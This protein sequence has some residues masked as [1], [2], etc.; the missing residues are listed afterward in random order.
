MGFFDIFS[1][2]GP[3][4]TQ[5]NSADAFS[6]PYWQQYLSGL[7]NTLGQNPITPYGGPTVAPWNAYQN[8]AAN[9]QYQFATNGTP[10]G[11]AANAA[12]QN[13]TQGAMNPYATGTNPY[14]GQQNA[15][16]GQ[17]V[18]QTNN[19][20]IGQ[21]NAYAGDNPY[22]QS[23][24]DSSN[25]DISKAYAQGIGAQTDAAFNQAGAYGGSAY[26]NQ[27]ANNQDMLA[28]N[29]AANT[30]N[31]RYNN[32]LNSGQ[33]AGQDLSRNTA[34]YGQQAAL[35]TGNQLTDLAR[36][37]SLSGTD[38]AR[39]AGLAGDYLNRTTGAY[40]SAQQRALSAAQLGLQSQGVDQNAISGLYGMGAAQQGNTQD[41]LNAMQ[42]YYTQSQLA[43]FT[44]YD[45]MGNAL[46]RYSAANSVQT[47]QLP[48]SSGIT[49]FLGLA[50][51]ASQI[52]WQDLYRQIFGGGP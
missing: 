2:D 42:N 46:S 19:P 20:Y 49:N 52:P 51:T 38:L 35:N 24:I 43:P 5:T 12:I 50:G 4:Q 18:G 37:A 30:S 10:T 25:A 47:A 9:M 48:G 8:T 22:L 16:T 31:L 7:N 14:Q 45:L 41:V 23:V 27:V 39:N 36:N 21:T 17:T 32:Y 33:L 34:A 11:N 26:Q 28:K 1:T 29:L 3:T 40:D 13:Q 44:G 6:T 15:Y